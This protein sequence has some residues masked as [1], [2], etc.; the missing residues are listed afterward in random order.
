[1][2]CGEPLGESAELLKVACP[3]LFK[4]SEARLVDP[5]KKLNVPVGVPLLLLT[6]AVKLTV[7]PASAGFCEDTNTV[8]LEF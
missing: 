6:V 1:M 3:E 8:V 5:S 7:L 4:V 2:P